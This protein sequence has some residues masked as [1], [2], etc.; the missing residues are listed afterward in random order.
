MKFSRALFAALMTIGSLATLSFAADA[1]TAPPTAIN[2]QGRLAT[3]SGNPVPDATYS[4]RFRFYDAATA[5]NIVYE[6]TISNVAV[7]N[8]TFAVKIDGFSPNNFN[9]NTWLGIKVGSDA[10]LTPRTQVISVPYAMK[11][12]LAMT[13][14]PGSIDTA[15]LAANA[16]TSAKI[17]SD[18]ASLLKVSGNVLASNGSQ[19]RIGSAAYNAP[20]NIQTS[21][22]LALYLTG[23]NAAGTWLRLENT[24]ASGHTWNLISS[25]T[26]NTEG[27]GKLL[28]RDDTANA[29]RMTIDTA[30]N[31]GIGTVT[32][33]VKLEVAGTARASVV[34]ITGGSDVAEPYFVAPA[35]KISPLPGMLVSIDPAHLGRMKVAARAYDRRV[36]GVISGANGINP[37]ITLRQKGTVADGALPVASIGRVW[38][39]CDAGANGAIEPGD[40]LTTSNTP[41]HAMRVTNAARSNGAVIGKAMSSLK[42]G[43]GLVLVLVS[44]K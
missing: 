44:L 4:I 33:T 14:P 39:R 11:S 20:F 29:V 24:L 22:L 41:G 30:G 15:A 26:G 36:G 31:V 38:V 42:K 1:Q 5:G 32:P 12:N 3:P 16:V 35:G 19:V 25:A 17:A 43:K 23:N 9:G 13:V 10:E 37:G 40:L 7:K 27:A 21:S 2:Y 8:G 34:E 6:Q 18:A 28:L